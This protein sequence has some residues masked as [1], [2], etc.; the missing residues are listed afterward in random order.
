VFS[1][2]CSC[3]VDV[4]KTRDEN[5]AEER[6]DF[7]LSFFLNAVLDSRGSDDVDVKDGLLFDIIIA[8]C[9]F[10]SSGCRC[11]TNCELNELLLFVM[12]N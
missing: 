4:G 5:E 6:V 12:R 11:D 8:F 1:A 10:N 7:N 3:V 9:S 2:F